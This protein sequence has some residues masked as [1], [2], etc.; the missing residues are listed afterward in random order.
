MSY[1][2]TQL[3]IGAGQLD[4]HRISP[5][6][7]PQSV[8]THEALPSVDGRTKL[9]TA[10]RV[11]LAEDDDDLRPLMRAFLEFEGYE[12]I[13]CRD[14][15]RALEL[16]QRGAQIDLLITDLEMP[17]VTGE[18]LAMQASAIKPGLPIILMSGSILS[19]KLQMLIQAAGWAFVAKPF[20]VHQMLC[21]IHRMTVSGGRHKLTT[22]TPY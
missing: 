4:L 8:W 10:Q 14:G 5:E 21:A 22:V 2:P 13:A 12:V 15:L 3:L 11:L 7:Y 19:E 17:E 18:H 20:A 9:E 16:L 6:D 1:L